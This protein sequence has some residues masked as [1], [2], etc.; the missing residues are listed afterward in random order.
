MEMAQ[1]NSAGHNVIDS[2]CSLYIKM[3]YAGLNWS[4]VA[5]P[6]TIRQR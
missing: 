1:E 2:G 3:M 5:D 4:S 6:V